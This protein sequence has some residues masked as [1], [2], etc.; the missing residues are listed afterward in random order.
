[1]L[2][3]VEHTGQETL[4]V[5]VSV[6]HLTSY[7]INKQEPLADLPLT[8]GWYKSFYKPWELNGVCSNNYPL[9][10]LRKRRLDGGGGPRATPPGS[11]VLIQNLVDDMGSP[12]LLIP[13]E[14]LQV[15]GAGM[16]SLTS[17][18]LRS[19]RCEHG[20]HQQSRDPETC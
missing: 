9:M 14:K 2:I 8:N 7:D 1:M 3:Q 10:N 20:D 13:P 6:C 18:E 15:M 11:M 4:A 16:G 12:V 17:Q 19:P 5:L